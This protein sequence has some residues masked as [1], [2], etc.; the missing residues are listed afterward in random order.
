MYD[1]ERPSVLPVLALRGLCVFPNMLT[2]FDVGRKKSARAVEEAMRADQHIFLVAQKD[3]QKDDPT[4]SDL[5]A[6][7]AGQQYAHSGRGLDARAASGCG[8][9]RAVSVRARHRA[10]RAAS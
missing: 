6:A 3:A 1:F 4:R 7:P 9:H 5:Y 10:C 8:A 2:H